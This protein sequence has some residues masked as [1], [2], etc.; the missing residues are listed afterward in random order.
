MEGGYRKAALRL[1]GLAETDR[2]WLLSQLDE[3]RREK[4]TALLSE[5]EAMGL[6]RQSARLAEPAQEVKVAPGGK[7]VEGQPGTKRQ[8]GPLDNVAVVLVENALSGEPAWMAGLI[9]DLGGP[10]WSQSYLAA[11]PAERRR[12]L[13]LHP[14]RA[15]D[16]KPGVR[17]ALLDALMEDMNGKTGRVG[18]GSFEDAL[19]RQQESGAGNGRQF[20]RRMTAWMH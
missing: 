6:S 12:A 18:G 11:L 19:Q 2:Q 14:V 13:Q 16:I 3:S 4:I 8:D 20:W 9:A 15:A 7:S 5:L 1:Y 17:Q 10:G